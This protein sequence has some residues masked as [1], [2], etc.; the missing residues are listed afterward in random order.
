MGRRAREL[1]ASSLNE[2]AKLPEPPG[3][4]LKGGLGGGFRLHHGRRVAP[5][6]DEFCHTKG[7]FHEIA[8]PRPTDVERLARPRR[9]LPPPNARVTLE[10]IIESRPGWQQRQQPAAVPAAVPAAPAATAMAIPTL[11]NGQDMPVIIQR[12]ASIANGQPSFLS[13]IDAA[14]SELLLSDLAGSSSGSTMHCRNRP[15]GSRGVTSEVLSRIDSPTKLIGAAVGTCSSS[16]TCAPL[17]TPRRA[18][19]LTALPNN[20]PNNNATEA[21]N[22][23]RSREQMRLHAMRAIQPEVLHP[24]IK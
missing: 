9:P 24:S 22:G 19:A 1:L 16:F 15:A 3:P 23:D 10:S 20:M 5:L 13:E 21:P 7:I 8:T 11:D 18:A 17:L 12:S 6:S 4:G 14:Y 2:L